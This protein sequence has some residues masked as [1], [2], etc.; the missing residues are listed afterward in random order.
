MTE[1]E[2]EKPKEDELTKEEKPKR[3]RPPGDDRF[4]STPND[5]YYD[6]DGTLCI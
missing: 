3:K 6:D 1:P 5:W 2:A 4:A